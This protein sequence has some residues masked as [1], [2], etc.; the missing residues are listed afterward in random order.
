MTGTVD[1]AMTAYG[2]AG[3]VWMIFGALGAATTVVGGA[4]S[5]ATIAADAELNCA[6]D[7]GWYRMAPVISARAG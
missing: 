6:S 2:P 1:P 5:V 7:D 4:G 3:A